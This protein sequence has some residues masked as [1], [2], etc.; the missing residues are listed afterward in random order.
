MNFTKYSNNKKEKK[1]LKN[2]A[3]LEKKIS[4]IEDILHKQGYIFLE[5][6]YEI[7]GI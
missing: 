2:I 5:T 1:I 4:C 7:L 3:D 6:I